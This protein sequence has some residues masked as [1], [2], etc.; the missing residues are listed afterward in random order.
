M[1]FK[2]LGSLLINCSAYKLLFLKKPDLCLPW[3]QIFEKA[4]SY[5]SE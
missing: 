3:P 5:E 2:K 4:F 1:T